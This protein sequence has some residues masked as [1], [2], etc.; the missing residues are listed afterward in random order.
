M[1]NTEQNPRRN[2][3]SPKYW[4][5][6]EKASRKQN[7][8]SKVDPLQCYIVLLNGTQFLMSIP[9]YKV[10]VQIEFKTKGFIY[11]LPKTR[12]SFNQKNLCCFISWQHLWGFPPESSHGQPN[13]E[14]TQTFFA[15]Q[16]CLELHAVYIQKPLKTQ[17]SMI[18]MPSD[19][20]QSKNTLLIF[21][22]LEQFEE[23]VT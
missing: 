3:A 20:K 11:V 10:V 21:R 17:G 4:V 2:G 14:N 16:S 22:L 8:I 18:I 15:L 23:P 7:V 1:I 13:V 5:V 6:P 9:N 19:L 12:G